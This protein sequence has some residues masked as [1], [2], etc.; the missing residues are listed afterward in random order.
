MKEKDE[1]EEP[2]LGVELAR[3]EERLWAE[4]TP[5]SC[6]RK[7]VTQERGLPNFTR[8]N[9]VKVAGNKGRTSHKISRNNITAF[10]SPCSHGPPY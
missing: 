7:E 9:L 3:L 2:R 4:N 10:P 6:I 1:R 5:I 8:L